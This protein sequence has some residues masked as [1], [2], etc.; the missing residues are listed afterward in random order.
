MRAVLGCC[1]RASVWPF[2]SDCSFRGVRR[3]D[4]FRPSLGIRLQSREVRGPSD[5]AGVFAV[6]AREHPDALLLIGDRLTLQHG[7]EIVDFTNQKR[8]PSTT[9]LTRR[10]PA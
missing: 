5:F 6:M 10:R 7:K 8:I 1:Q 9:A 2:S 4:L 3:H